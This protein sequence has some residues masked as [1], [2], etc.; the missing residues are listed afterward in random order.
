MGLGVP[1]CS[2]F[3]GMQCRGVPKVG[4]HPVGDLKPDHVL[5]LVAPLVMRNQYTRLLLRASL[6]AAAGTGVALGGQFYVLGR[7]TV[8]GNKIDSAEIAVGPSLLFH[9]II[10][11]IHD[12]VGHLSASL[13]KQG[14]W[15]L[16]WVQSLASSS[17]PLT[18]WSFRQSSRASVAR[19]SR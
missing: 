15:Y 17:H 19:V 3:P 18:L 1:V 5:L 9:P 13:E 14:G 16:V 7:G 4:V 12:N 10:G 6:G 11:V 8:V 2:R